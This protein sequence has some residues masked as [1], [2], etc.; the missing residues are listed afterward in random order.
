M[1]ENLV[2]DSSKTYHRFF[3]KTTVETARERMAQYTA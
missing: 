1:L 2:L 3:T